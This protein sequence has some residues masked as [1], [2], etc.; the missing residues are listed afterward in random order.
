MSLRSQRGVALLIAVLLILAVAAFG[1]IIAGSI[2]ASDVTDSS[3]QGSSIEA[4]YAADT[5]LERAMKQFETGTACASL[6]A[7]AMDVNLTTG[8][9]FTL[10]A[11]VST[12]FDGTTALQTSQC[13]VQSSGAVSGTS[14]SRKLQAI[15]D[16]NMLVRRNATF[17][18]PAGVGGATNWTATKWDYTGG[19]NTIGTPAA[20]TCGRAAYGLHGKGGGNGAS[21]QAS[22]VD[23]VNG[24][25]TVTGGDTVTVRFNLRA[26]KLGNGN[27][28]NDTSAG[29]ADP[30]PKG[31]AA[32]VKVWVRL[33]DSAL[34]SS[35]SSTV[36]TIWKE[37]VTDP[38]ALLNTRLASATPTTQGFPGD[39]PACNSF[40][41]SGTPSNKRQVTVTMQG[42][43]TRTITTVLV[44]IYIM[45]NG[46]SA[47]A[48][49]AWVDNVELFANTAAPVAAVGGGRISE[50]RD[51]AVS[52]CP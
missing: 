37:T 3:Y 43:G 4:L 13:R 10:A 23:T 52:N 15:V 31:T 1:A 46:P 39:Y 14:A 2:A 30:D 6:G 5:G 40:Y 47:V 25:F 22:L 29:L 32:D 9:T 18:S 7:A 41:A 34:T 50:W 11:G 48:A 33:L 27:N 12:A 44:N 51:C 26:I 36:G 17:D 19:T 8:R 45:K 42:A 20:S 38:G 24:L 21:A 28:T 49:E 35:D 16:R